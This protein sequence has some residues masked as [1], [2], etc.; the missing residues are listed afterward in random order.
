MLRGGIVL[1]A[2]SALSYAFGLLR[3]RTLAG[4]F[5]ASGARDVYEAAFIIP[6]I[7]FNLFLAG[8]LVSA[9]VPVFTEL[10]VKNQKK[11]ADELAGGILILG[12][13]L[14]LVV[15]VIVFL[16]ARPL[17]ALV[18]PGFSPEKQTELTTLTRLMLLSPMLFLI[19]NL[20]G[21]MLLSTERFLAYGLS[22]ILYNLGIVGGALFL[23]PSLGIRG[24]VLGTLS[25]AVLHAGVRAIGIWRGHVRLTP[26]LRI[27][28]A[29]RRV[30]L[31]MLPRVL[32]L[33]AGQTQLWAFLA[34]GSTLGEGAVT[35]NNLARNFQSFP[36]SILGIAFATSLF[37][38]LSKSGSVGD[39]TTYT[40]DLRRGILLTL[41]AVL[42]AAALL[43]VLRE[44]IIA[45]FLGTGAFGPEAVE[46]TAAV[47]GVYTLSIPF[48]SLVHVLARGFYA[49]QNTLLPM[50][51]NLVAIVVS[52]GT[53]LFLTP[54]LG[55]T[56]VPAGFA[57]GT[58]LQA[59]MLGIV[60]RWYAPRALRARASR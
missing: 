18:G 45:F 27:T 33:T 31:L 20:F 26:T 16:F 38:V 17:A 30:V 35:M 4:A 36:V 43:Y 21:S 24:V 1:T 10:R 40:R 9:F 49:L 25:G 12:T 41:A 28:P 19:S 44:Q 23:A 51:V 39:G 5:G 60:L 34:I 37:P 13:L 55:I 22:P 14:L 46:R 48:E 6:D 53:A 57:A 54:Q 8:A 58:A 52:V 15:G 2:T 47:L 50:L 59:L 11:E 56:G 7:L 29:L 32:G 42:P 3:D